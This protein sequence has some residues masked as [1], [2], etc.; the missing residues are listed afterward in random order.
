M[1]HTQRRPLVLVGETRSK[2]NLEALASLGW[3]RMFV[4]RQPSPFPFERW[5]FD[6]GAF[7][8]GRKGEP[9]PE[10]DFLRR[11]EIAEKT[12]SDPYL[13]VT[14][15]IVAG[16]CT[17][18]HF[19][20]SWR[21]GHRLP[22]EWPWYLAVQDGMTVADVEPHLHLYSGI[23]LGGTDRFKATAYR[24]CKLAHAHQKKFHYARASTPGK[25]LSA[26]R[27]GADSCDS[28]FP[29]WTAARMRIFS[30]RW[31][32]LLDQAMLEFAR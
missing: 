16:G 10:S 6:N 30:K 13:A 4:V 12:N 31:Q 29:L 23:F 19:S 28:A 21:I 32:G 25:L 9:F 26:F 20:T 7:I 5:G 3:G 8:A 22:D 27:V 15:D 1:V 17:S 2:R 18:L 11:L 14:P 24:W